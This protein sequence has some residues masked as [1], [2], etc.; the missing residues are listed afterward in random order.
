MPALLARAEANEQCALTAG[1][2]G[3]AAPAGHGAAPDASPAPEVSAQGTRTR[4]GP[5][6][7]PLPARW[8]RGGSLPLGKAGGLEASG[9]GAPCC[10][11]AGPSCV[12]G[13]QK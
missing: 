2:R 12:R 3:A 9:R 7:A 10:C 13:N 5:V 1:V 6:A 8:C 4:P 11:F